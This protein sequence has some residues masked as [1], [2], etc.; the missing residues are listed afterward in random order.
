MRA[1]TPGPKLHASCSNTN[2]T[3]VEKLR[4][5]HHPHHGQNETLCV[6]NM[7]PITVSEEGTLESQGLGRRGE[8]RLL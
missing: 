4:V 8:E 3:A 7:G 1:T 5:L 6:L 2:Y